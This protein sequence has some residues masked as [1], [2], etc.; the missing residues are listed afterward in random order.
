MRYTFKGYAVTVNV[1][2]IKKHVY[3]LFCLARIE[4]LG[5]GLHRKRKNYVLT[6]RA[7]HIREAY[8][9]NTVLEIKKTGDMMKIAIPTENPGGLKA[10]RSEHFG[11]CPVFTV[12][13]LEKS[14]VAQVEV[15]NNIPHGEGGCVGPVNL[16]KGAGV[17]AIVVS[18]MGAR[19]M[20]GFCDA[21][22]TVYYADKI[23]VTDAHSAVKKFTEGGLPVMHPTQACK[24]SGNCHH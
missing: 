15:V 24:G 5:K 14:E 13:E 17:E 10:A 21:G 1:P 2:D 20:Q 19:P 6:L 12:V 9:Q 23:R 16:L 18:G 11:H 4:S 8:A 22:I 3:C 7:T